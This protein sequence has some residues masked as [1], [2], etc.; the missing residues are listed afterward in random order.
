MNY[1]HRK[2]HE[3]QVSRSR[4]VI[5]LRAQVARLESEVTRLSQNPNRIAFA[6]P[7][8]SPDQALQAESEFNLQ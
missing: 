4:E 5:S 1:I 3:V 2:L 7:P 6:S 8:S